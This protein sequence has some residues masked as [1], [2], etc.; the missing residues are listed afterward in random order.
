MALPCRFTPLCPSVCMQ[1]S[2]HP[3][4]VSSSGSGPVRRFPLLCQRS[5]S[6]VLQ[7]L[8]CGEGALLLGSGSSMG[9]GA[10][11]TGRTLGQGFKPGLLTS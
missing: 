7:A 1:D 10:R 9:P 3:W 4:G 5:P 6:Q 11:F 8:L 2:P